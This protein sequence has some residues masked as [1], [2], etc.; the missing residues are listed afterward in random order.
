M[1][2]LWV[3]ARKG[4][5]LLPFES[6][7]VWNQA[8]KQEA[9]ERDN[10]SAF[11]LWLEFSVL[12]PKAARGGGGAA[13]PERAGDAALS[14]P[15]PSQ[16]DYNNS[17]ITTASGKKKG[18]ACART[19]HAT[20]TSPARACSAHTGHLVVRNRSIL[21][22]AETASLLAPKTALLPA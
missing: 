3:S 6:G 19:R 5:L 20:G 15:P 2:A 1:C 4:N 7:G 18:R 8:R 13:Q 12:L 21:R 17:E 22:R 14:A 16:P 11:Q 10:F 9:Q